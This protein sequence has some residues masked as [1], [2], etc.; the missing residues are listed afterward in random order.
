MS[1]RSILPTT[2]GPVVL[3]D[4]HAPSV[5]GTDDDLTIQA[6]LSVLTVAGAERALGISGPV[7]DAAAHNLHASPVSIRAEGQARTHLS[8]SHAITNVVG[9]TNRFT[10]TQR[11]ATQRIENID[12]LTLGVQTGATLRTGNASVQVGDHL[13][14]RSEAVSLDLQGSDKAVEL[15]P[16]AMAVKSGRI[17][18][19]GTI[20][21]RDRHDLLEPNS[22]TSNILA[23]GTPQSNHDGTPRAALPEGG[24]VIDT[25]GQV[26]SY[27]ASIKYGTHEFESAA[28]AGGAAI[29][30]GALSLMRVV[31]RENGALDLY[32]MSTRL[33]NTGDYEVVRLTTKLLW[34]NEQ[35][36]YVA[37]ATAADVLEYRET[38]DP[39]MT[40]ELPT[41]HM[42]VNVTVVDH[43]L[44][45]SGQWVV[46]RMKRLRTRGARRLYRVS[47][48]L[49]AAGLAVPD[50]SSKD[51]TTTA[52]VKWAVDALRREVE[53]LVSIS[54]SMI[55]FSPPTGTWDWP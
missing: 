11:E 40:V 16:D 19:H 9:T 22:F 41:A 38:Y 34:S 6:D 18:V 44:D 20:W 35:N 23:I 52:L 51:D 55:R 32:R 13:H 36:A 28:P 37:T 5:R 4:I 15:M 26:G 12:A 49:A 46:F 53:T 47:R 3:T 8:A 43:G 30:G 14:V 48:A 33:T 7:L 17:N 1:D 25:P 50:Q 31:P 45:S 10:A 29:D 27:T 54:R 2:K 21:C 39:P 42:L 24:L